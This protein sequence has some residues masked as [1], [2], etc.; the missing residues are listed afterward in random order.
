MYFFDTRDVNFSVKLIHLRKI[1]SA[2]PP[3][4]PIIVINGIAVKD[5]EKLYLES[6]KAKVDHDISCWSENGNPA[7]NLTWTIKGD[8]YNGFNWNSPPVM[9]VYPN[10]IHPFLKFTYL[11]FQLKAFTIDK[12]WQQHNIICIASHQAYGN[13]TRSAS[14]QLIVA[15]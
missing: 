2:A 13:N 10:S 3:I 9:K 7:A 12:N 6:T 4:G 5:G 8:V 11:P 15:Y 1:I 14:I